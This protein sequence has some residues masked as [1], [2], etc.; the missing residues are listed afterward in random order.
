MWM[1]RCGLRIRSDLEF[2]LESDL[3]SEIILM[4]L[5]GNGVG[6]VAYKGDG[7]CSY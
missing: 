7:G 6:I 2:D 5:L 1:R 3:E 4:V